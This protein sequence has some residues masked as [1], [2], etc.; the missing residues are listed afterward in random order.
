MANKSRFRLLRQSLAPMLR[1]VLEHVGPLRFF[2]SKVLARRQPRQVTLE[3]LRYDVPPGDFGV[4]LELLGTGTYEP[5]S[6]KVLLDLLP[7]GGTFIDVGAHVGLFTLP[8]ARKVGPGGRVIAFEPDPDNRAML[9]ANIER[10]G[11]SDVVEVVAAAVS[12]Q[13]G[14]ATLHR[15]AWNSGDHRLLGAPRGRRGIS[16]DVVALA[17]VIA[18]RALQVDA[19]KI[20]VQ[21][22]EAR[23][24]QGLGQPDPLPALL[25]EYSP[26]MMVDAGDDPQGLLAALEAGGWQLQIIDEGTGDLLGGDAAFVHR[27]CP[28][29]SYVNLLAEGGA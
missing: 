5:G 18:D 25:M 3:G 27:R 12:S 8:A 13:T 14:T 15:S 17:D 1:P 23:V 28:Y 4:T 19:I 21:G 6:L 7:E 26:S 24:L 11:F 9:E 2:A 20:D 16:V 22:A 10:N 29:R